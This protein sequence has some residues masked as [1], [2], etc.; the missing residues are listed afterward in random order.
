MCLVK[1]YAKSDSVSFPQSRSCSTISERDGLRLMVML[2]VL[3]VAQFQSSLWLYTYVWCAASWKL[4]NTLFSSSHAYNCFVSFKFL[5]NQGVRY[6]AQVGLTMWLRQSL[7]EGTVMGL[8]DS[9]S[10]AL[11]DWLVNDRA[12][13]EMMRSYIVVTNIRVFTN[14]NGSKAT[15]FAIFLHGKL[16]C[17]AYL[18]KFLAFFIV[19]WLH[20][21]RHHIVLRARD[22]DCIVSI[23]RYSP[24][25]SRTLQKEVSFDGRW[26]T[27]LTINGW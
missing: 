16:L 8:S 26:D 11:W 21:L 15:N 12:S 14:Q 19:D 18:D 24:F 17:S 10:V 5:L 20:F 3:R 23:G 9:L 13:T 2:L 25:W 4:T 22:A 1:L 7:N 6:M 27:H